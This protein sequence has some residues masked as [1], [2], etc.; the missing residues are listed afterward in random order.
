MN[1][2]RYESVRIASLWSMERY[3]YI[4]REYNYDIYK[5]IF[6]VFAGGIFG[7]NAESLLKF[8]DLTKDKCIKVI[9]EKSTLMWEANIWLLVYLENKELLSLYQCDDHNITMLT[10][11]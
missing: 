9:N 2:K 7:G 3:E 6:W 11:Y 4:Y 8:A 1:Y 10:D 5:D